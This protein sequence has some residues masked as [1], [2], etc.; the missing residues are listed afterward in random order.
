MRRTVVVGPQESYYRGRAKMTI[1][2]RSKMHKFAKGESNPTFN[3]TD[4][5]L[6]YDNAEYWVERIDQCGPVK[7]DVDL[8][9]QEL[10]ECAK[11]KEVSMDVVQQVL[12]R[13]KL[14]SSIES[15]L[16]SMEAR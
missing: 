6:S 5:K 11:R 16:R 10:V 14:R 13:R 12:R 9:L 7:E 2:M 8:V 1:R 3:R 4:K 15:V